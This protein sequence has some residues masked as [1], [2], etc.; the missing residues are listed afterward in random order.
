MGRSYFDNR[1]PGEQL[2]VYEATGDV[3][4]QPGD[5]IAVVTA[6]NPPSPNAKV[7][8]P[9]PVTIPLPNQNPDPDAVETP[10]FMIQ[11]YEGD[12]DSVGTQAVNGDFYSEAHAGEQVTL[13][14][15]AVNAAGAAF[16]A[17]R[18]T[19]GNI[20]NVSFPAGQ[21]TVQFTMP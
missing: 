3:A 8:A 18:V 2:V 9:P 20:P 15:P 10:K 12:I 7:G 13:T 16:T 21:G 6:L 14:A 17:W 1:I 5:D 11:T 4:V 19:A